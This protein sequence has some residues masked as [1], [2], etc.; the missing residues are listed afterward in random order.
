[1][2]VIHGMNRDHFD[3]SFLDLGGHFAWQIANP[4]AHAL[5]FSAASPD[6]GSAA[7]PGT[8]VTIAGNAKHLVSAAFGRAGLALGVDATPPW[9]TAAAAGVALART[10]LASQARSRF[11]SQVEGSAQ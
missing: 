8:N 1:M 7:S 11:A 4:R 10:H 2:N 5:G 9:Q 6:P 3:R